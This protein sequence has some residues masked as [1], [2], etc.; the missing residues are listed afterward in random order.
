MARDIKEGKST[1]ASDTR[2][3][4]SSMNPSQNDKN[5]M[6]QGSSTP[7]GGAAEIA[8]KL[9]HSPSTMSSQRRQFNKDHSAYNRNRGPEKPKSYQEPITKGQN[10]KQNKEKSPGNYSQEPPLNPGNSSRFK[11]DKSSNNNT[12]QE[13]DPLKSPVNQR[14]EGGK[15]ERL[16]DIQANM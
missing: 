13:L 2:Q 7:N 10:F 3:K 9:V 1:K 14:N 4:L 6:D 8:K 11:T 15:Q 16:E 12:S 5:S